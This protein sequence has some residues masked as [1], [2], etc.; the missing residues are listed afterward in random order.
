[1][2]VLLALQNTKKKKI[3][4]GSLRKKYKVEQPELVEKLLRDNR[5]TAVLEIKVVET[6]KIK[7]NLIYHCI[8]LHGGKLRD[9]HIIAEDITDAMH[10]LE[11]YLS[12]GVSNSVVNFILGNERFV[13]E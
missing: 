10:K 9:T 2:D 7:G 3:T 4:M 12:G 1:L 13:K 8:Y 11:P 6:S 5:P